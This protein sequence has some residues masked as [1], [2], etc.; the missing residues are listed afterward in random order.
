MFI[1]NNFFEEYHS[2][3]NQRDLF[4]QSFYCQNS[5]IPKIKIMLL[6]KSKN[7]KGCTQRNFTLV[8]FEVLLTIEHSINSNIT[9]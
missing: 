9:Q 2:V 4:R 3:L 6:K 5:D 7:F 8:L 1:K